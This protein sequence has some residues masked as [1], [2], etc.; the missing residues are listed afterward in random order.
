VGDRV[1]PTF[2]KAT[3]DYEDQQVTA[4][5]GGIDGVLTEYFVVSEVS[6]FFL[7]FF[8]ASLTSPFALAQNDV[9][10]IPDHLTYVQACTSVITVRSFLSFFFDFPLTFPLPLCIQ[11]VT[12]WHALFGQPGQ[13]LK[14][15]ETVLVLGTGGVSIYAAQLALASGANV[16]ATSSSDEK[17]ER[18]K[19]EVSSEIKTVN[20]SKNKNWSEKVMELTGGRGVDHV[21]ESTFSCFSFILTVL[22]AVLTALLLGQSAA[23]LLSLSRFAPP[24]AAATSGLLGSSSSPSPPPAS[25]SLPLSPPTDFPALSQLPLDVPEGR[26]AEGNGQPRR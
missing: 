10:E 7:P 4:L 1:S 25:S 11:G 19:R 15:G 3:R 5:G 17:L 12:S 23:L 16:I 14:A 8:P 18:L 22:L 9:V 6:L 21:L 24:V 2:S 20:Y 26:R 13:A